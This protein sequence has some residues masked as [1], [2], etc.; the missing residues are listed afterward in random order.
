MDLDE[1]LKKR[2]LRMNQVPRPMTA[3]Y[4]ALYVQE[5]KAQTHQTQEKLR[6]SNNEGRKIYESFMRHHSN[7]PITS[8]THECTLDLGL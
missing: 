7:S 6:D 4:T 1:I 2:I 8:Q 3:K 5:M